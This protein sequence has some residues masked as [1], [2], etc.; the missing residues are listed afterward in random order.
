MLVG[1]IFLYYF[2]VDGL[3][4][5]ATALVNVD[6]S[7]TYKPITN[8]SHE[9]QIHFIQTATYFGGFF[10]SF[11]NSNSKSGN[12]GSLRCFCYK[13]SLTL[14]HGLVLLNLSEASDLANPVSVLP[15][16]VPSKM[17]AHNPFY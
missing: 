3:I 12:D 7:A 13:F 11:S 9:L 15:N 1:F 10:P 17:V 5:P 14:H 8:I 4:L 16:Y 2:R 6:T